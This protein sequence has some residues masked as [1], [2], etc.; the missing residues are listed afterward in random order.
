MFIGI[1]GWLICGVVFGFTFSKV[2][3][4]HGDDP[5]IGMAIGGVGGVLGGWLYSLISGAT[6][7]GFNVWSLVCAAIVSLLALTVWHVIRARA[8]HQRPSIR[9]SY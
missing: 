3:N 5:R 7:S 1:V 6:V 8:P 2:I 9:R 4:L